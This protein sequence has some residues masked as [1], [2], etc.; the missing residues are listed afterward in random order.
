MFQICCKRFKSICLM[1]YCSFCFLFSFL[2]C[3][4]LCYL[5]HIPKE[6]CCNLRQRY[7]EFFNYQ[8]FS[9][10]NYTFFPRNLF[11]PLFFCIL[12][13]N[14]SKKLDIRNAL[15]GDLTTP[16]PL[17]PSRNPSTL[18]SRYHTHPSKA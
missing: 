1:L 2:N 18:S 8:H 16:K 15:R 3:Y 13:P 9:R 12:A 17:V 11:F 7:K 6:R 5:Q 4:T 14:T 10:K